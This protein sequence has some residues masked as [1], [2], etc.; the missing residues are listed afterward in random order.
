MRPAS[1]GGSAGYVTIRG[2]SM[3]PTYV[4]G[5][6]VMAALASAVAV[7]LVVF[8]KRKENDEDKP[9]DVVA[10]FGWAPSSVPS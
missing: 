7:V 8:P 10:V 9:D 6:L 3:E 5:D 2:T 1:L 4:T